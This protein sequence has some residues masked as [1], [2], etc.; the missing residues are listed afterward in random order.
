MLTFARIE[1]AR[2]R[3]TGVA[4]R[5]PVLRSRQFDDAANASVFFK[6][7]NLQRA[8]AFKFRGAYNKIKAESEISKFTE[9]VAYSSGNHAQ[10]VALVSK[11]LGLKAT[12][13]MPRDAPAAKLA[14]TRGYGAEVVLYDRYSESRDE[15][16]EKLVR[17]R[18]ALLV[19]PFDD[20]RIMAG[21]AT[22]AVEL[23]EEVP[24]L[25]ALVVPVS[26]GG[27][28]AGCA[29]AARHLKPQIAVY[30][31]EPVTAADTA[32]SLEKGERVSID[33]PRTIADGLQVCSPGKL[34]FPIVQETVEGVLLVSDDEM[35]ETL[36][37]ML[38]RMKVLVEPSGV[39]GAA[40]V[41]HRK[42]DF[43]GKKVGVILSGGNVDRD[44]LAA[45]LTAPSAK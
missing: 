23:L 5:T 18:G 38:E 29:F 30:G 13:V 36:C 22:A 16:G 28:I 10:A 37:W 42:A 25:D 14:A 21:A 19:P 15:I 8:G 32:E 20:Y 2:R 45:Y 40:A 27:L 6:A 4:I 35:V 33:V 39:A 44:R 24:D 43:S 1:E 9:V 7:E 34:T 17:D 12:I 31:T 26:G 41:R 11:I 3:L